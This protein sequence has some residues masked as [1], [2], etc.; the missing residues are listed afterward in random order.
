VARNLTLLLLLFLIEE[1]WT[2]RLSKPN[3]LRRRLVSLF[4]YPRFG[5]GW[6]IL[7]QF[8]ALHFWRFKFFRK[9]GLTRNPNILLDQNLRFLFF[10]LWGRIKECF[11][12]FRVF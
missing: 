12:Y 7:V 8:K 9:L 1:S 4:V 2:P 3:I 5:S 10:S 11:V 6:N